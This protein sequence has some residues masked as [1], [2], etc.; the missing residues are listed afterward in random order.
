MDIELK[1]LYRAQLF[2]NTLLSILPIVVNP[3]YWSKDDKNYFELKLLKL[4]MAYFA[5]PPPILL[6]LMNLV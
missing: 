1:Q 3:P 5:P 6:G 4:R 2:S